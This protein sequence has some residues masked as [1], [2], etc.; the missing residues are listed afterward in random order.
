MLQANPALTPTLVKAILEFTA[1]SRAGYDDLTEGAGFLNARGAVELAQKMTGGGAAT[2]DAATRQDDPTPWSRHVIWGN[3]LVAGEPLAAVP[4]AGAV[5]WG[6][7][8]I[9]GTTIIPGTE[10][11]ADVDPG[12][13]AR[14][15]AWG[16]NVLSDADDVVWN[17]GRTPRSPGGGSHVEILGIVEPD[18][19]TRG[20]ERGR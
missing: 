20:A 8:V 2:L 14:G 15:F 1:E 6:S 5:A 19:G 12:S 10:A 18:G 4:L 13:E 3:E 11:N 7:T 9:P 17:R 16:S